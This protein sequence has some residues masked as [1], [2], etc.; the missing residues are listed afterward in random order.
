[1]LWKVVVCMVALARGLIACLPLG[2]GVLGRICA[3]YPCE[4]GFVESCRG[5]GAGEMEAGGRAKG[6]EI[7]RVNTGRS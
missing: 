6:E 7:F 2:G 1:M 5:A 3:Q 4:Q